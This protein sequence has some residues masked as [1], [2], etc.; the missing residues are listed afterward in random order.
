[1]YVFVTDE[2]ADS[3]D[4][5]RLNVP[6]IFLENMRTQLNRKAR[7]LLRLLV[8]VSC[9]VALQSTRAFAADERTAQGMD[10]VRVQQIV[11][12][13]RGRLAIPQSVTV[14]VVARNP[15]MVSVGPVDGGFALSFE[16]GF[17]E[18]LT[19]DELTAAVAHELGHVWIYTHF[20]FLQTEQLANEIA[21]RVVS[22]ESL[23]P[24][25]AR[26]FERARVTGDV[27][28]YLGDPRS[29]H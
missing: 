17:A 16:A 11:D 27:N 7:L 21:M 13:L 23:V 14:S 29:D 2:R 15:L 6:G 5:A 19:D 9:S 20:P 8:G 4:D 10:V 25:Y 22:R 24:V 1:L 28:E 3:T 12:D 18:R 26:V